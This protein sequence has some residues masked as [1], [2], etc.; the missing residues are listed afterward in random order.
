MNFSK[1]FL[2]R[3]TDLYQEFQG[4]Y[5]KKL[6]ELIYSCDTTPDEFF[7]ALKTVIVHNLEM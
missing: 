3:F 6:E 5:E 2:N 7:D 1:K 4:I